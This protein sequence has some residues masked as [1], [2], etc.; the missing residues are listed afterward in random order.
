MYE[1]DKTSLVRHLRPGATDEV[2]GLCKAAIKS[3]HIESNEMQ[4]LK[5]VYGQAVESRGRD[6]A[7]GGHDV[8][9]PMLFHVVYCVARDAAADAWLASKSAEWKGTDKKGKWVEREGGWERCEH[10]S[11]ACFSE[12]DLTFRL[13]RSVYRSKDV[14]VVEYFVRP[15]CDAASVKWIAAYALREELSDEARAAKLENQPSV[16]TIKS[17]GHVVVAGCKVRAI[18][19]FE[20]DKDGVPRLRLAKGE[21]LDVLSDDDGSGWLQVRVW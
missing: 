15:D 8:D 16:M 6:R 4:L 11:S 18:S 10:A 21:L 3:E 19:D 2:G 5:F 1:D 14:V 9:T 12:A 7:K 13:F 17:R 20:P